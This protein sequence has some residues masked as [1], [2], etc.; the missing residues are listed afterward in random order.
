MRKHV[1]LLGLLLVQ[2]VLSAE[3]PNV[4]IIYGDDIG[5]ADLG[6][7]GATKIP[8]PNL[9]RLASQGLN[10]T[11]GHCPAATCSASRFTMLTGI[12]AHR[13][14]VRII[15]PTSP[16]PITTDDYTLPNLF[17]DAGY[18]TAVIGKW[19]LGIGAPDV[20]VDWNGV[21]K[22]G[23]LEIGFDYSFLLPNTNDRVPCVYLENHH[24]VG[25]DPNDPIS[26][27]EKKVFPNSTEYP[28][29]RK[30]PEAMTYY[31]NSH[32]HNH[33]VINGIGRIGTQFGG[34]SALW[35][36]ETM[37]DV[38]VEKTEAWLDKH[39]AENPN[40]P[41]FLYF[42]S[43]DIHVPRTPHPRFRGK[44]ELGYRGDAMVQLDWSTGELMRMLDKHNLTENTL[45]IF[46]SDN[47]PVYDDGYQDGTI[48]KTSTEEID[49][50]HDGS[51]PY[52]GGKY[53]IYEGGTRVPFIL[54]WP[55]RIKPGTSS[56]L[57]SH[58][59]FLPSFAQLLDIKL[60]AHAAPDAQANL[61]AL[62][63][64]DPEG[65]PYQIQEARDYALR[66]GNWKLIRNPQIAGTPP[67]KNWPDKNK[68][69]YALFDLSQDISEQSNVAN[70]HPKKVAE[71]AAILEPIA[72]GTPVT[73]ALPQKKTTSAT[74]K[75]PNILILYA[76]DLGYGDL[77]CYNPA[78]KIP[79]PHLDALAADGLLCT[80][81]HSSSGI[82]TPSRYALLTGRYHWRDFHGIVNA[83][84]PSAFSP[85]RLTLP[86]ML[87]QKG[88]H[89]ACIGKWHLGW[90]WSALHKPQ[91]QAQKFK[92][93][94]RTI[95]YWPH[96][97][98]DWSRPIPNGPLAH[99]FDHYFGDNVI[100]FPPYCWI[101]DDRV[102]T[103]PNSTFLPG[104]Y[105]A[106]TKEGNW[107]ARPGPAMKD[108]NFYQVLPTLADRGVNYVKSRKNKKDPF[109]L[110]FPFPS[111]HA[112]IIPN[113][114]FDGKSQA[115]PYGDFVNQTDH[116]CGRLIQALK[117]TGQYEN[118]IIL[119]TADNGPEKYAYPRD[120]QYNHWSSHPLRGL[121]R[122]IYEGGH[123]VPFILHWPGLTQP[124]TQSHALISQI[125]L[126]A[127]FA[128]L[129]DCELPGENCAEDSHSFLPHLKNPSQT[130][131]STHIHNT[132]K[133]HYAIR[134]QDW[135][136][137]DGKDGYCSGRNK[138]FET[139]NNYPADNEQ[140][141]ELYNLKSDL[142][143][144][145]NLASKYPQKVQELQTL[146]DTI[147]E[148]DHSRPALVKNDDGFI[149]LFNGKNFDGWFSARNKDPDNFGHFSINE[150]EEA[151]HVY[152]GCEP[153]SPQQ[154]DVISTKKEF[155]HFI[156]KMEYKWLK[157]RFA[158]RTDWDRD[159]GL[160]FHCHG[161]PHKIWPLCIEMQIGES[162]GDKKHQKGSGGR[163][164]TGD[165][166]VLGYNLQA[167]TY[168]NG[169]R[170][171]PN[172]KPVTGKGV[173]TPLGVE[174]PFGEW[175]EM[176]I[177]V[178][179]AKKA[180]F[181]LNGEIVHEVFDMA[182]KTKDGQIIPLEKGRIA[183]QAE[184]AEL[185][186]R[187]IRIKELPSPESHD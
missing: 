123:R 183:M 102:V 129:L 47:G 22:P 13:R 175:N 50:G 130:I 158:P 35:N 68:P 171:D 126:F 51:G 9:D 41:F 39:I 82:C 165:L 23:P 53:Q 120:E 60:P 65:N 152:A 15:S 138:N 112:P 16:L 27:G 115:G 174:K 154:T 151:I 81:G 118:T 113:D 4:I 58:T 133:D 95:T 179:G 29:G 71:L 78:S 48:V 46:S 187:N 127:T 94:K 19:H 167:T 134:H 33:T 146:L 111:P 99:G 55:A 24:V 161:D 180:T 142:P 69:T 74:T 5:F 6:V 145:H 156:L 135:L 73:K 38:F 108:W 28:D 144:K 36:D 93:D 124:G 159:A 85:E 105:K 128:E 137:I 89:T 11:D 91:A 147:R 173:P 101:L 34:K 77:R 149:P 125:D 92:T 12:L 54:R 44:S 88:Y 153:N 43:Q 177:R 87:Q 155:S 84:G 172:G 160:L 117:D 72:Q 121:K 75:K 17:Q 42:A 25:L 49:Q 7:N 141:V 163:F 168:R 182:R 37:A 176:E 185:L 100:N 66:A 178:E 139:K 169:H 96:D 136:L 86:E 56:A 64:D 164:H 76:D 70:K 14:D 32:G 26:I 3:K 184:W 52:R 186:Y 90:N 45:V 116:I 119:F 57:V 97:Q 107:E 18:T 114:E 67:Y 10:F 83:L 162:P 62:L 79:T 150:K 59:D 110:Y 30:T 157:N 20:P 63:G 143:Q 80:D 140:S 148:Q 1:L 109:F 122:D 8:T 103:I 131:R 106:T 181:L 21:V 170:Y 98:L 132:R 166:F 2:T 40:Q 61:P 31:M 104:Q